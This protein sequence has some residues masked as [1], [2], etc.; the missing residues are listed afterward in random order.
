MNH[1]PSRC[2][3]ALANRGDE[4]RFQER[5]IRPCQHVGNPPGAGSRWTGSRVSSNRHKARA[6][7]TPPK[8]GLP[9]QSRMNDR[10]CGA[11]TLCCNIMPIAELDK[12][13]GKWCRFC[14]PGAAAGGCSIYEQRPGA[15]RD[16]TCAWLAGFLPDHW[17][18]RRSRMIGTNSGP[19]FSITI[20][21]GTKRFR[22]P[23]YSDDIRRLAER[24]LHGRPFR[25]VMIVASPSGK[26]FLVLP[27]DPIELWP[28]QAAQGG[29]QFVIPDV[30]R[31]SGK[32]V[33]S[34]AS[35]PGAATNMPA[36]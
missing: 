27:N 7:G 3:I 16:F 28:F 20:E 4:N 32:W 12:P 24:C 14:Q 1:S 19:A 25:F 33:A 10:T 5:P 6:F 31:H 2:S 11:C 35:G 34:Y 18:P 17:E 13:P 21:Q 26:R 29:E 30:K 15:S 23:P 9:K 8:I 36:R 22:E